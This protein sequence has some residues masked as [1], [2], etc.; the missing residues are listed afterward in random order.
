MKQR[1]PQLL[2]LRARVARAP[3]NLDHPIWRVGPA[4]SFERHLGRIRLPAT[5]ERG[6]ELAVAEI[7]EGCLDRSRPLFELWL[8][9]GLTGPAWTWC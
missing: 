4:T 8:V 2:A 6:F 7:A 5:S 1:V 9:E 3:L